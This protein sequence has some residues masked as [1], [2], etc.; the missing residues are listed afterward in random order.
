MDRSHFVIDE[1]GVVRDARYNVK[2]ASS[3]GLSLEA[4]A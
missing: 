2:A 3:A 1:D 4:L